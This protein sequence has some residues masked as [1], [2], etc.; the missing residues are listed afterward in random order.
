MAF[1]IKEDSWKLILT[2][3]AGLIGKW[4]LKQRKPFVKWFN[5]LMVI[6]NE[7]AKVKA[8]LHLEK[9]LRQSFFKIHKSPL[10]INDAN[11]ELEWVNAAWLE[12]TGF[13]DPEDAYGLGFL[14]AIPESDHEKM[15]RRGRMMIDH[16]SV[17]L[18]EITFINIDTGKTIKTLCRA[19]PV[20]DEEGKLLKVL[21]MLV[22]L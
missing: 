3:A 21:G 10:F 14:R 6:N 20:F 19:D 17:Y 18:G 5:G 8:E 7:L 1:D 11:M 2:G 9:S 4:L 12:M 16:P 22:I 13:R 15:K